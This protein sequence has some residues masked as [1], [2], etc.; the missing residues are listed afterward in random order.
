MDFDKEAAK[1]GGTDL[2]DWRVYSE[3]DHLP[4]FNKPDHLSRSCVHQPNHLRAKTVEMVL[5]SNKRS[6][7]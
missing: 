6:S 3:P 4:Y 2:G 1:F 5:T 7:H